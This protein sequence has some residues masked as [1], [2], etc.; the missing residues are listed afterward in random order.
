MNAGRRK[1]SSVDYDHSEQGQDEYQNPGQGGPAGNRAKP[2]DGNPVS[3]FPDLWYLEDQPAK[4]KKH[5]LQGIEYRALGKVKPE[6]L[7]PGLHFLGS[8]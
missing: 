3:E 4:N 8:L 7:Q 6:F 2:M 5:E 1:H